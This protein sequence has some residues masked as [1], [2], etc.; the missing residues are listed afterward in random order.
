MH[1]HLSHGQSGSN[2]L[3]YRIRHF[4]PAHHLQPAGPTHAQCSFSFSTGISISI[5]SPPLFQPRYPFS[6]I[7]F[8]LIG[9]SGVQER[10]RQASRSSATHTET[11]DILSDH[12]PFILQYRICTPHPAQPKPTAQPD[13]RQ[14][15]DDFVNRNFG[16]R[17]GSEGRWL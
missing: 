10:Q 14:E 8:R 2:Y 4:R 16:L 3:P 13:Q 7:V 12:L 9:K 11:V 6:P 15:P 1:L 5:A 17:C